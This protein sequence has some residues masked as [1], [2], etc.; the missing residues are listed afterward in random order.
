MHFDSA[1]NSNQELLMKTQDILPVLLSIV[2]IILVAVLEKQSKLAAAITATM[3]VGASL[4]L[5]IVYSANDGDQA[6]MEQFSLGLLVG[7]VPT[8]GFIIAAWLSSRAGL[9]LVPMFLVSFIV[10]GIMLGLVLVL[11]KFIGV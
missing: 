1:R 10:W 8:I 5:W 7:I 3:P 9:S 11:R 6:V 4:A 2:V